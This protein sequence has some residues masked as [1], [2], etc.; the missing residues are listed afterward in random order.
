MKSLKGKTALITGAS[1]GI[2]V[3][4]AE[5]LALEGMNLVLVARSSDLLEEVAKKLRTDQNKIIT[6]TA[7]IGDLDQL[8]NIVEQAES[9]SNGID[10]LVNNAGVDFPYPYDILDI[11]KIKW[12]MEI[13]L[14]APM[15]LTRL[16]LPKMN[17]RG[18]GHIVNISS[19]AGLVGT[20]YDDV[21]STSKHGLM[22]FTR[23]LQLT[24]IGESYPVGFSVIC[25]GY[26]SKTGMYHDS[27]EETGIESHQSVGISTPD[28]VAKSV[29][30]AIIK[31]KTEII[32]NSRPFRPYL[33]IQALFPSLAPWLTKKTG[34]IRDSKK[35]IDII[36]KTR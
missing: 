2:G 26:I 27:V 25:P 13:N 7:N 24:A 15:I 35:H 36:R 5:A 28:I 17:E 22:G 3:Y 6:I 18:R 14:M 33:L 1:K 4:I 16:I 19:L 8:P 20:P 9:K 31:N 10:V 34:T 29:I 32:V 12:E 11:D 30:K 23:S 21:Y